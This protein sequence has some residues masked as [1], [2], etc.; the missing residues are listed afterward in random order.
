[1]A[2]VLGLPIADELVVQ[3]VRADDFTQLLEREIVDVFS[4]VDDAASREPRGFFQ[5]GLLVDDVAAHDAVLWMLTVAHEV[6]E[7]AD[8][9]LRLF[10]LLLPTRQ[11]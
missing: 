7:P 10:G 1:M 3:L 5:L 9:P 6:P 4:L 2:L 11:R 8:H